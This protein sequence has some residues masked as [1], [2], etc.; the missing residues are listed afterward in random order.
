MP[1]LSPTAGLYF[2]F[3]D[4]I[5]F[6]SD[7]KG[8]LEAKLRF[9]TESKYSLGN[10][11]YN[12]AKKSY[13]IAL[14]NDEHE[15][16]FLHYANQYEAESKWHKRAERVDFDK[17]VVVGT[18]LDQCTEK[19]IRDFDRMNFERKFFFTRKDYNLPSTI[20]IKDFEHNVK[21]GDPYRSG[22]ILYKSL[23]IN[24]NVKQ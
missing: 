11:R 19:D 21:I 17:L 20:Y 14:L 18:E 24:K 16:H 8:N 15:I 2:F 22:H 10:E 23:A 3:P 7:L 12:K 9:V 13:P 5:N 1:Y 4:Y 6:L